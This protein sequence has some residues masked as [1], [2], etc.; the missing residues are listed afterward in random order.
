MAVYLGPVPT[1]QQRPQAFMAT[2]RPY[3]SPGFLPS[4]PAAK[5]AALPA[6]RS[7]TRLEPLGRRGLGPAIAGP[8]LQHRGAPPTSDFDLG[9]GGRLR[10]DAPHHSIS[11]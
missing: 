1:G 8:L 5:A 2:P 10:R 3:P 11:W 7:L 6:G 4:Q 9:L